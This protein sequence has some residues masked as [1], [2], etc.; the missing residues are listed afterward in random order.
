MKSTDYLNGYKDLGFSLKNEESLP[1]E[2]IF[3]AED[4]LSFKK[5]FRA[6][7]PERSSDINMLVI[8]RETEVVASGVLLIKN[9]TGMI[10]DIRVVNQAFNLSNHDGALDLDQLKA[11]MIGGLKVLALTNNCSECKICA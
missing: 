9:Q 11:D 3:K 7:F 1:Q 5:L 6:T 4:S 10:G 8:T 2:A